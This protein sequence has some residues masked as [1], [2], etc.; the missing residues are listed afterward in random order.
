MRDMSQE[1][2]ELVALKMNKMSKLFKVIGRASVATA[3]VATALT[4]GALSI[5]QANAE[6]VV[7][8]ALSGAQ[9]LNRK[10]C[11]VLKVSFNFRIQYN[12]H[13][14]LSQSDELRI[15][16]RAIDRQQAAALAL[17]K[18]EAIRAPE[19]KFAAIKA[20]DFEI[21]PAGAPF[22][23]IQF[24]RPV[25]YQ[26]A[27]GQDFE[28]LIIA[29]SGP[30]ASAACKPEYARADV[31]G[32][33]LVVPET[34]RAVVPGAVTRS[35]NRASGAISE[36]DLRAA[37]AA[38][39]EARAAS[40]KGNHAAAIPMLAKV[41]KYPENEHSADAQELLAVARHK[42]GQLAEARAEY[43]DY[44]RRYPTWRRP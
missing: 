25:F 15:S 14:P 35:T 5:D 23:R 22:L 44:L 38:M 24:E 6:P 20:I 42:A 33:T 32:T 13:F 30:T 37:A 36:A 21:N 28:S 17:L 18:R 19:S 40:R 12:S 1:S 9:M 8:R 16:V 10:G 31:W 11:S 27:Q 26:V 43:E 34:S 39:D 7:D 3:A 4:A 41:L 2:R 29:I